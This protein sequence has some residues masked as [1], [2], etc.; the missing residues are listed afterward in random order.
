MSWSFSVTG[1]DPTDVMTKLRAAV[2]GNPYA[3]KD[4]RIEAAAEVLVQKT[5][6]GTPAIS[7]AANGHLEPDGSGYVGVTVSCLP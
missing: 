7:V 6:V 1:T 4:G 3:P 2:D 5:K